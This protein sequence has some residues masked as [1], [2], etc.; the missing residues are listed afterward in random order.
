MKE[1]HKKHESER[2]K[3]NEE[4]SASNVEE[5]IDTNLSEKNEMADS[6]ELSEKIAKLESENKDLKDQLLRRAADMENYRKRMQKEKALSIEYA[7]ET[8]L[9]DLLESLDNFDRT[10]QAAEVATDV[11]SIA[12]G[13][14]MVRASMVG[15]LSSKHGL[16]S[17]GK[18]GDDFDPN[19][20]EALKSEE[21]DVEKS[22]V[23]EVYLKGYMLKERVL[24]HAKV[25]VEVPKEK[26]ASEENKNLGE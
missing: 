19:L 13:V 21:A 11:K 9:S 15:M 25:F 20:H 2:E 1:K 18:I 5:K 8:L 7:N 17:F 26:S 10:L 16:T 24:R 6:S 4:K 22:A 23:K 14:K 3:K 12:E